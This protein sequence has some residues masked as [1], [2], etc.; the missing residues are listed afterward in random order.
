MYDTNTY[1]INTANLFVELK[2]AFPPDEMVWKP[3][4]QK[5]VPLFGGPGGH[6]FRITHIATT[7]APP[8]SPSPP[9]MATPP[10]QVPTYVVGH[11]F[12]YMYIVH[13]TVAREGV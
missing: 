2:N 7:Q 5:N 12:G 1:G 6:V 3:F 10:P 8:S 13:C 11:W 9:P 4:G